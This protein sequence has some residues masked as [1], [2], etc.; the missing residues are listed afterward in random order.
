[1]NSVASIGAEGEMS[2]RGLYILKHDSELG[3]GPA[4]DLFAR[5]SVT[6][7]VKVPRGIADHEVRQYVLDLA[8]GVSLMRRV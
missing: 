5:I 8:T 6:K 2:T 1:M 3:N 7:K 4:F